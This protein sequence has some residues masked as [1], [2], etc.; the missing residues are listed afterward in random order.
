MTESFVEIELQSFVEAVAII[1]DGENA[2]IA[3]VDRRNRTRRICRGGAARLTGSRADERRGRI[4]IERPIDSD[5]VLID[6]VGAEDPLRR[7]LAFESHRCKLRVRI[8]TLT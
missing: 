2:A 3:V 6:E 7:Q 5:R 4:Q 1:H 8:E